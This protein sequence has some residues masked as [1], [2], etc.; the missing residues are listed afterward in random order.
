MIETQ[1]R[2]VSEKFDSNLKV[3]LSDTVVD[4]IIYLAENIRDSQFAIGDILVLLCD[5][6][7]LATKTSIIN[8]IAGKTGLTA[9]MLYDYELTARRWLPE[10]RLQYAHLDWTIYR[11]AD[12]IEDRELLEEAIDNNYSATRFK[13]RKYP[14]I[15]EPSRLIKITISYLDKIQNVS[16]EQQEIITNIRKTLDELLAQL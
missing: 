1:L 4:R 13:E 5:S 9:N 12:P 6:Q 7:P 2:I 3:Q 14:N 8:Y 15:L 10:Y 16:T 11:N